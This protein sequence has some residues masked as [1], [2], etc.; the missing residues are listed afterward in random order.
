MTK[1]NL[2]LLSSFTLMLAACAT[3]E[4]ELEEP[5][6]IVT[7]PIQTCTPISSV[8][9]VVIPAVTKTQYV[10]TEIDN[11]PY[12]PIQSRTE[13]T[14]VVEEEKVIYVNS[15]GREVLDLCPEETPTT[16]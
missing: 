13:R 10:I 11:D 4:P 14:V 2:A 5:V 6:T 8:E 7:P 9:R 16:G 1:I 12:P 15:E 3:T